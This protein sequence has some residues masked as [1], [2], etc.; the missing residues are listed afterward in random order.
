M[1][2][3]VGPQLH[4]SATNNTTAL[5]FLPSRSHNLAKTYSWS[6]FETI[7]KLGNFSKIG[8]GGHVNPEEEGNSSMGAGIMHLV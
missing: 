7:S 3:V 8:Q 2:Y 6:Y 5:A 1:L 4:F